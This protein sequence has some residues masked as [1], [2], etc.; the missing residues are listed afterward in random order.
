[1][2]KMQIFLPIL[3]MVF[4][5]RIFAFGDKTPMQELNAIAPNTLAKSP[6][7]KEKSLKAFSTILTVL[8]SPRCINCHPT[9]DVPHQGDVQRLHLFGVTRGLA[10]H[11]GL[12]Q[13]C[14]TC[15]QNENNDFAN[16]P[17]APH[18]GLAPKTMGWFGLS[19]AEI[20]KRLL[21][22][23]QNGGRSPQDLVKHMG[24]DS[25]VLW[26]WNPGKTRSKPPV[27]LDA[28]RI[29][30]KEWLDNGAAIPTTN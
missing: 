9:T 1:M 18:W 6:P 17:G 30:L 15:H 5:I 12:V 20:A 27:E 8:K 10:N 2:K 22:K 28:W 7:D 14:G 13:K 23:N 16:V 29:V 24:N 3:A 11:G 21:D 19:D 26:A 4:V 25:L